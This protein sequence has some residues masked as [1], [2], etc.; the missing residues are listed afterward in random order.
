ME[1]NCGHPQCWGFW[2]RTTTSWHLQFALCAFFCTLSVFHVYWR[3]TRSN[4]SLPERFCISLFLKSMA[5]ERL[6]ILKLPELICS[7]SLKVQ[8][9][10]DNY[11]TEP[12]L[13]AS[14]SCR[15]LQPVLHPLVTLWSSP[16]FAWALCPTGV[17][18][19]ANKR[20]QIQC[21]PFCFFLLLICV[22][23]VLNCGFPLIWM[24]YPFFFSET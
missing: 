15:P 6:I 2:P 12:D 24:F 23:F 18:S 20:L 16:T 14:A 21:L 4:L 5:K 8:K 13:C 9:E 7:E 10:P 17:L 19:S 11:I 22:L 3:C 1:K